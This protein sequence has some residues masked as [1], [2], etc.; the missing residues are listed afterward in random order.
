MSS[1]PILTVS[2]LNRL[3]RLAL[4]KALPSC[5]VAGEISN[6]SRATSGHWYFTLKDAQAGVRCAMFRNR[7]QFVDWPPR[8]GDS[9]EVRAQ[10]TLYEARGDYQLIV[11]AMRRAGA[12][13]LFEAFLRLK[14]KLEQE[15]LFAPERKRALPPFPR[16]I[17][18]ITSPQAAALRDVLATLKRRW[19]AA[20]VVLYPTPV[21]GAEA[22]SSLRAALANAARRMECDVLLLVRGGGSLED[23]WAFNDE[24]LARAIA[25]SPVPVV[26]G[27][28]HE[29][30]FTIADFV[31]DLRAPT[32][33]G[34]A[35]LATPDRE[36]LAQ[37]LDHLA[38]RQAHARRRHMASLAQRLDSLTRRLR[39]PAQHLAA[40]RRHLNHLAD[41]LHLARS[42]Q[43]ERARQRLDR[44]SERL[45]AGKP[46]PTALRE[47]LARLRAS[48]VRAW[49]T[50][51]DRNRLAALGAH[52]GHLNPRAVLERGYSITRDAR[53]RVVRDGASLT[54][55]ERL[56]LTFAHGK[57][58]A[59]VVNR[60]H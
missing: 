58:S 49:A 1:S 7:N 55:G 42:T 39:H 36:E 8:E 19:P 46:D 9:V 32:P 44:L 23:L 27:V 31:A 34:A 25:A 59:R 50:H 60:E 5:W 38:R 35:Q 51:P 56:D 18:V 21:Q 6:L 29:T 16:A 10:P 13:A 43:R 57:A 20:T 52:L 48:L 14:A 11:E 2:E 24:G 28:G 45:A 37:H 3:A 33:T 41:R 53:G 30:D 4:E 15:G 40:Q 12:G 26:S 54:E 22:P 17:G 47:R